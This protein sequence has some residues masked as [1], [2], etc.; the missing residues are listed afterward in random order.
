MSRF[1]GSSYLPLLLFFFIMHK[2]KNKKII[3]GTLFMKS[4]IYNYI[5]ATIQTFLVPPKAACFTF[6]GYG[7]AGGGLGDA[8]GGNGAI[9]TATYSITQLALN[10]GDP[11]YILVGGMGDNGQIGSGA[12][13][14]PGNDATDRATDINTFNAG[15]GGGGS[16]IIGGGGGGGFGGS[17]GTAGTASCCSGGGG[18]G[19]ITGGGGGYLFYYILYSPTDGEA[20]FN[21]KGGKGFDQLGGQTFG[22]GGFATK[23]NNGGYGG[24]G[25]GTGSYYD[26]DWFTTGAGGGGTFIWKGA[27]PPTSAE[28]AILIAGGGGGANGDFGN[29]F[30]GG[31]GGGGAVGGD[32]GGEFSLAGSGGKSYSLLNSGS[33]AA[34]NTGDGKVVISWEECAVDPITNHSGCNGELL[35]PIAFTGIATTFSWVNDNPSI[36]LPASGIGNINPF[37]VINTTGTNIIATFTVT[38]STATCTGIPTS[39]TITAEPTPTVDPLPDQTVAAGMTVGPINFTGTTDCFEWSNSNISIGLVAAGYGNIAKF[40]A[41]NNTQDTLEATIT[42]TPLCS[43]IRN[44]NLN[45]NLSYP[46][47]NRISFKIFVDPLKTGKPAKEKATT[48]TIHTK[49][50]YDWVVY[51]TKHEVQIKK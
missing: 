7:A 28:Q 50:L 4:Q 31:G 1:S 35:G 45:A 19:G 26:G 51:T 15:K 8:N 16:K 34:T 18:G 13:S 25:A 43:C 46:I 6:E 9:L 49:A 36:G 12:H 40:T 33:L 14:N 39:F 29:T 32:G 44:E 3:F 11:I 10:V 41:Q 27:N 37:T 48:A 20:G 30:G 23:S 5:D 2:Y 42:V 21:G 38:P 47:N 24:G 17:G 22:E